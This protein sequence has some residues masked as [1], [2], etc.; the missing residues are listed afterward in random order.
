MELAIAKLQ[1]ERKL[2][3][4]AEH[5][6]PRERLPV[7]SM[8][9]EVRLDERLRGLIRISKVLF[10]PSDEC[11]ESRGMGQV[12]VLLAIRRFAIGI[13]S[14]EAE[15]HEEFQPSYAHTSR[16]INRYD[17]QMVPKDSYLS[18][19]LCLKDIVA[20][21]RKSDKTKVEEVNGWLRRQ[22][23]RVHKSIAVACRTSFAGS[24][25]F[26][27]SGLRDPRNAAAYSPHDLNVSPLFAG[28]I[29]KKSVA[30]LRGTSRM[31]QVS[32]SVC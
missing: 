12:Q 25:E 17:S 26:I 24:L 16:G 1:L 21:G 20:K 28:I 32:S 13:A 6:I 29:S 27:D 23:R 2:A 15:E 22:L 18:V 19:S 3:E 30:A 5:S 31:P 14:T 7:A 9:Q 8:P 10:R 11:P 4:V